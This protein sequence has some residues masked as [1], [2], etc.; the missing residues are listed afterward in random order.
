MAD[1]A[2]PHSGGEVPDLSAIG[3]VPP[4]GSSPLFSMLTNRKA[5]QEQKALEN[6]KKEA[7]DEVYRLTIKALRFGAWILGMLVLVRIWHLVGL[8][9]WGD[10]K[11]RWLTTEDLNSI[12]KMLFSGA[13]GGLVLGHL[14][15]VMKPA[16]KD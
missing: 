6:P 9:E 10:T 8:Y 5:A 11:L 1:D 12:D 2:A 7:H 4:P 14:K 3:A 13:F 15:E 16:D